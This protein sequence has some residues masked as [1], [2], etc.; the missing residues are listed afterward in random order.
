[1][2]KSLKGLRK[3]NQAFLMTETF[4]LFLFWFFVVV[5]V[6]TGFLCSSG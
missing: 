3:Q 1:M 6:V 5:V 2:T 4:F